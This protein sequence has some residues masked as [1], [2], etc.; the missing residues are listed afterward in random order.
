VDSSSLLTRTCAVFTAAVGVRPAG[1]TRVRSDDGPTMGRVRARLRETNRR[2]VMAT[3][4]RVMKEYDGYV[5][6]KIVT[7]RCPMQTIARAI[8]PVLVNRH[9]CC[10]SASG[11]SASAGSGW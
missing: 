10:C 1:D 8:L 5:L 4:A 7:W 2:R 6:P 3:H 11:S 9:R